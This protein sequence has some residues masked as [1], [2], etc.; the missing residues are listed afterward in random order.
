[1]APGK[2][3]IRDLIRPLRRLISP[4]Y[5]NKASIAAAEHFIHSSLFPTNQH[6]AC[7]LALPEEMDA[8]PLI[9]ALQQQQK[10]CYVPIIASASDDKTLAFARY[11]QGTALRPNRYQ[12]LEPY[13]SP[14]IRSAHELDIVI[15]PLLAFDKQGNRLGTGGGFYDYTFSFLREAAQ[16]RPLL[17]GLAYEIQQVEQLPEEAFDVRLDGVLTEERLLLFR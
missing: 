16:Q 13:N 9:Q 2:A 17:L 8:L 10:C 4:E 3:E 14:E 7:Y 12:I 6:L 5:R 11:E 15:T 1:M